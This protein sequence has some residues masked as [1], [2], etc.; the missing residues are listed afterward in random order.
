MRL[1][2][3]LLEAAVFQSI[4]PIASIWLIIPEAEW[5]QDSEEEGKRG[6]VYLTE[7]NIY[8]N[9]RTGLLVDITRIFTEREIDIDSIHSKTSKQ[10]VATITIKFGT[11]SRE[12]LRSLVE[13]IKQVESIIDVERPRG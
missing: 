1:L 6:G 4:V 5:A 10:G 2:A 13:K 11:Q 8:G 12:Q 9:N 3:L 7:I